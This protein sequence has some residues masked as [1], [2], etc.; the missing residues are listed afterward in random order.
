[1]AINTTNEANKAGGALRAIKES[2]F[3]DVYG[4]STLIEMFLFVSLRPRWSRQVGRQLVKR[5]LLLNI[6][7]YSLQMG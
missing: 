3:L 6:F 4:N 2:I 1:M 5:P 7:L